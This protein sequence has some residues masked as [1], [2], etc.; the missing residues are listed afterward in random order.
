MAL[1]YSDKANIEKGSATGT[2]V[3]LQEVIGAA[4]RD[5]GGVSTRPEQRRL[6]YIRCSERN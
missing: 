1:S 3:S 2:A 5:V 6:A 4:I